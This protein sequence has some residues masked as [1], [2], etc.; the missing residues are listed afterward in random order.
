MDMERVRSSFTLVELLIIV[1]ILAIIGMM[2]LPRFTT[3]SEEARESALLTD[4][5]ITRRQIKLYQTQHAGRLP[6]LNETG[7]EDGANFT[8]RLTSRTDVDGKLNPNGL[9]GPYLMEWPENPF[10]TAAVATEIKFAAASTTPRDGTTGWYYSTTTGVV[11]ANSELGGE[12]L[13]PR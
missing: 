8:K 4:I 12:T 10:S 2:V 9:M 13:D 11:S 3:A 7:A 5:Q 6:H 1:V